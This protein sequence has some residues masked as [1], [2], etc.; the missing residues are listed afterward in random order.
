[1]PKISRDSAEVEDVGVLVDRSGALDGWTLNFLTFRQDVDATPLLTGAPD[2]RC[3]CP[4]W[5]YVLQGRLTYRVGD[6]EEVFE[7]GDAFY[8]PPGHIP[9]GNEPGSEFVQFSPTEELSQTQAVM[10]KNMAA[11]GVPSAQ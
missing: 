8:L 6:R 10:R 3:Q 1:V 7:A 9:V 2:D 4:H 11:I 5:G